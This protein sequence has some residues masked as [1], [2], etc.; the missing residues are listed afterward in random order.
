MDLT[1]VGV[2][3][4]IYRGLVGKTEGK[5]AL[6]TSR[7]RGDGRS[8]MGLKGITCKCADWIELAQNRDRSHAVVTTVLKLW[9]Q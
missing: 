9:I 1:C 7:R 6:G 8:E 2:K 4:D 5:K 3:R